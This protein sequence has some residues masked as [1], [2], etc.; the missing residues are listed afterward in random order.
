MSHLSFPQRLFLLFCWHPQNSPETHARSFSAIPIFQRTCLGLEITENSKH[1]EHLEE[2]YHQPADSGCKKIFPIELTRCQ[3]VEELLEESREEHGYDA[4]FH[5][6]CDAEE[7]GYQHS[8]N[9]VQPLVE[10]Y[11]AEAF[12]HRIPNLSYL[13]HIRSFIIF[14]ITIL[15][16]CL[17]RNSFL[18]AELEVDFG[19]VYHYKTP[20]LRPFASVLVIRMAAG[21]EYS[22]LPSLFNLLAAMPNTFAVF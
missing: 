7:R 15:L 10:C 3:L 17:V 16:R 1:C 6:K 5:A 11:G 22:Y 4:R 8:E 18:D 2:L 20:I 14:A 12:H 19:D 9:E 21:C 13:F